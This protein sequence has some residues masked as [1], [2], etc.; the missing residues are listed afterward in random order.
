MQ[1]FS[2]ALIINLN[3][4]FVKLMIASITLIIVVVNCCHF[5]ILKPVKEPTDALLLEVDIKDFDLP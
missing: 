4:E 3:A 5:E 2:L 1:I